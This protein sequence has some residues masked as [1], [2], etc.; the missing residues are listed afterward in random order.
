MVDAIIRYVE[1]KP[2]TILIVGLTFVAS[3]SGFSAI[4]AY[5]LSEIVEGERAFARQEVALA[6]SHY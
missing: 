3:L 1:K 2:R 5:V 4:G 6:K